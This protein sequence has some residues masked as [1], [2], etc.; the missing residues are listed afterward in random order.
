MPKLP[1]GRTG[2]KNNKEKT[3]NIENLTNIISERIKS[4]K[5]L[6]QNFENNNEVIKKEIKVKD[7]KGEDIFALS[8]NE[9]INDAHVLRIESEINYLEDLL[10]LV[11]A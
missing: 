8:R 6:L 2:I 10:R 1:R 7:K 11:E 4:Q 3:M 9:S 5:A